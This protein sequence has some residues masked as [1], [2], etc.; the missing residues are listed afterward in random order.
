LSTSHCIRQTRFARRLDEA[1][2]LYEQLLPHRD[3]FI[4]VSRFLSCH[5][6]VERPLGILALTFGDYDAANA[7]LT[8]SRRRAISPRRCVHLIRRAGRATSRT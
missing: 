6:S 7:H 2:E 5:G 1:R 3:R 8:S 4:V